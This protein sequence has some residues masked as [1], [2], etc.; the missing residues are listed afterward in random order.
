MSDDGLDTIFR[1]LKFS[2]ALHRDQRRKDGISPYIN[3]PIDVAEMIVRV[4]G[5]SNSDII[6]AALMHDT[7]EDTG[8]KKEQ[9]EK[10]FGENVAGLVMEC[11]DDK[12]LPKARRKELQVENA[13]HKSVGARIV[14]IADKISNISDIMIAPPVDWPKERI[15][16]YLDWSER[17]VNGLR[18]VNKELEELYDERLAEARKKY[19]AKDA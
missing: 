4:G 15:I 8:A 18:G 19:V 16:E 10:L 11:T 7:V 1:A 2:A 6:C 13:S 9:I 5:V 14:K 17:V 12:S 3:H